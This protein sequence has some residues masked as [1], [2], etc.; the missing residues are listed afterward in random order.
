M[1]V[2]VGRV[3]LGG[4]LFVWVQINTGGARFQEECQLRPCTGSMGLAG[5]SSR[6][7]GSTSR[8]RAGMIGMSGRRLARMRRPERMRQPGRMSR[9]RMSH[10]SMVQAGTSRIPG[11]GRPSRSCSQR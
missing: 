1:C 4:H 9:N 11:M 2:C 6:L 10:G 7:V 8:S 5:S 3:L